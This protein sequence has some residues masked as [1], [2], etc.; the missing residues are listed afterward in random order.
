MGQLPQKIRK[1][2][3][4]TR[5]LPY[6]SLRFGF[7]P[8][9]VGYMTQML[10]SYNSRNLR[11]LKHLLEIN[12]INKCSSGYIQNPNKHPESAFFTYISAVRDAS[13]AVPVEVFF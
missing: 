12:L 2:L 10:L 6:K 9:Y 8:D 5:T 4:V 7:V 11:F 3:R 13:V 1:D